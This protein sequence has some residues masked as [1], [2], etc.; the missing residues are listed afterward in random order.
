MLRNWRGTLPP[1]SRTKPPNSFWRLKEYTLKVPRLSWSLGI[2]QIIFWPPPVNETNLNG[3][4]RARAHCSH[5]DFNWTM[6]INVSLYQH[7][8]AIL[9]FDRSK[10]CPWNYICPACKVTVKP[11]WNVDMIRGPPSKIIIDSSKIII[12]TVWS[13]APPPS[14]NNLYRPRNDSVTKHSAFGHFLL[15]LSGNKC[16]QVLCIITKK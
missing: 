13:Y 14:T 3:R 12:C 15:I 2:V 16:S 11:K 1:P 4:D 7:G 6:L 5:F 8:R 10:L 9:A